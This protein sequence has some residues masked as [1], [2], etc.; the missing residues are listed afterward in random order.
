[1]ESFESLYRFTKYLAL[2]LFALAIIIFFF[3]ENRNWQAIAI[4]LITL[5]LS[6][7]VIDYFSEERANHY[8][9]IILDYGEKSTDSI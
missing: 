2:S 7:L 8:Y 1:M 5:G 6:G 3:V 9:D 4:A